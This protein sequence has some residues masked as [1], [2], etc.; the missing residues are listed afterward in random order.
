MNE[1]HPADQASIDAMESN[2]RRQEETLPPD[3]TDRLAA[4]RRAAV[5]RMAEQD[6]SRSVPWLSMP[7]LLPAGGL[8]AAGVVAAILW[9]V[10]QPSLQLPA[11]DDNEMAAATDMEML[12]EIEL[13][14]WLLE[15]DADVG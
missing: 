5:A 11:L 14:A 13:I 4:A 12:D 10:P 9:P 8:L 15:Q 1:K 3:V 2:L 7:R 6:E